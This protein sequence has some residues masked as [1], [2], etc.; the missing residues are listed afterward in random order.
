MSCPSM[1][2]FPSLMPGNK[3][4]DLE[5]DK[6]K[7]ARVSVVPVGTALGS[8]SAACPGE[9]PW[10]IVLSACPA[11]CLD[12]CPRAWAFS[13]VRHTAVL[14]VSLSLLKKKE[15]K[16]PSPAPPSVS[17]RW[18][19]HGTNTIRNSSGAAP[20]LIS[21]CLLPGHVAKAA[22]TAGKSQL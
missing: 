3:F 1:C 13:E 7:I 10:E 4:Y 12:G 17:S 18:V 6:K 5:C 20:R 11:S 19:Q 15:L 9:H 22:G 8:I 21:E 16:S 2:C 14:A